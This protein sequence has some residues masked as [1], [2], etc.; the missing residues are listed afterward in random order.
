M[1]KLS[2]GFILIIAFL[3]GIAYGQTTAVS[4]DVPTGQISNI[5]DAIDAHYP[6]RGA[7][8]KGNWTKY[9]VR[10]FLAEHVKAFVKERDAQ[11]AVDSATATGASA[12]TAI[13]GTP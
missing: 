4:V 5:N 1:R 8:S 2:I 7:I 11:S 13:E 12:A 10:R 3:L 6:G 9:Q